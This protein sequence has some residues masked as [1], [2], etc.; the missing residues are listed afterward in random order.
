M[1]CFLVEDEPLVESKDG[2]KLG[3]STFRRV[4][5]PLLELGKLLPLA[6]GKPG[7]RTFPIDMGRISGGRD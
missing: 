7:D 2:V 6:T 3:E 4:L 1:V 5:L